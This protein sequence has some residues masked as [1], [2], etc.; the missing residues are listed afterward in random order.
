MLHNFV[1]EKPY[2][3]VLHIFKDLLGKRNLP[4]LS[5]EEAQV[6]HALALNVRDEQKDTFNNSEVDLIVRAQAGIRMMT[7]MNYRLALN[8]KTLLLCSILPVI[9]GVAEISFLVDVNFLKL[10]RKEKIAVIRFFIEALDF[11]PFRRIQAKVRSDF[12]IGQNFVEHLGFKEEGTM[13]KFGPD[14]H[15]YKMYGLLR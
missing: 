1:I 10:D 13:R 12:D 6:S 15:D 8:N 9:S 11:L 3:H 5:L 2:E 4:G 14:G 7:P